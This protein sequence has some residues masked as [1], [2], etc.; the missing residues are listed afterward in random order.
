VSGAFTGHGTTKD[1]KKSHPQIFKI[2][3]IGR[4]L[5]PSETREICEIC[6]YTLWFPTIDDTADASTAGWRI[7]RIG[8]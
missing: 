3:Q 4:Q 2:R 1:A 7:E 6:G 5:P 8:R